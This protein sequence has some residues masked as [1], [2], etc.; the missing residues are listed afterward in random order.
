METSLAKRPSRRSR[1]LSPFWSTPADRFLRNDFLDF[2]DGDG[3][4]ETIPSMN[5]REEKNNFIIDVAAPGLKK[6][7]FDINVEGDMLTVSSEK[8]SETEDEEK[9]GF[10]RR[11]YSY[12]SFSRSVTLPDS[13]D[14]NKIVAKYSD[15]V[16]NLTIPKKAETQ[17]NNTQKIKVQ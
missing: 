4:V 16:L 14:A 1:S 3:F 2:W 9:N 13:V 5:V 8:E 7:D 10:S 11:E 17:K 12:S 6:E 15:G